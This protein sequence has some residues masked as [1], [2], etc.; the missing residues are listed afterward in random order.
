MAQK[1]DA[2][3]VADCLR[4]TLS[5]CPVWACTFALPLFSL[6]A[7]SQTASKNRPAKKV[8]SNTPCIPFVAAID[9]KIAAIAPVGPDI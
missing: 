6:S 4:K 2:P 5:K 8:A 1:K 7:V 9:I 3:S